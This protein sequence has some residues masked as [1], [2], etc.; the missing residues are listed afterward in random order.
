M[1]VASPGASFARRVGALTVADLPQRRKRGVMSEQH[2]ALLKKARE[3]LVED[4]RGFAKII[5]APF[6]R[7]RTNDARARFIEMQVAIEAIDR[8]IED[9]KND[10]E[11]NYG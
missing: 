11:T 2:A 8:A 6:E 7:E 10:D 4:R 9:E 1:R 5:A 3:R